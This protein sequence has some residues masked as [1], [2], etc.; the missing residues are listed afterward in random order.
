M[1]QRKVISLPTNEDKIYKQILAF[2]N[3]MLNLTPQE[4]D[5]LAELI[6]LDNEYEALPPDKRAKFILS[7]DMRK[8]IRE[9]LA[10]EEKQFNVILSKLKGDKKSFMGKPLLD[11]N[12][13]LHP[14]LQFKPDQDGF[15]FEV[16]LIMTTIPTNTKKFTEELDEGIMDKHTEEQE[17]VEEQIWSAPVHDL[18]MEHAKATI[19]AEKDIDASKAPILEE[20]SFEFTINAPND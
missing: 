4:R 3:F 11:E 8:E 20:E 18:T 1:K 9:K 16:N 19:N 7:T 13:M 17:Y 2:M 10:I 5:I 6:R 12:N 14:Q 15:Q